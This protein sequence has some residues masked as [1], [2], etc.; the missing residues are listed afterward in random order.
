MTSTDTPI[1]PAQRDGGRRCGA[2][3]KAMTS[4][5]AHELPADDPA[6]MSEAVSLAAAGERV[7]LVAAD[8]RPVADVVPPAQADDE[9]AA[10]TTAAFL[11]ATG[12]TA[13]AEGIRRVYASLDRPYPGDDVSAERH[14][15]RPGS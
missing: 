13:T 1:A 3:P 14:P 10:H 5:H 7:R 4:A 8:G 2:Y 6:A 12:G 15:A 11:T 9:R